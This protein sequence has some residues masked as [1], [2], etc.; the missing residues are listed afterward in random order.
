MTDGYFL[1]YT[2]QQLENNWQKSIKLY[3]MYMYMKIKSQTY[4]IVIIAINLLEFLVS[5][6][7]III[8][9]IN[10]WLSIVIRDY[11]FNWIKEGAR[12]TCFS[13]CRAEEICFRDIILFRYKVISEYFFLPISETE[14]CVPSNADRKL[15]S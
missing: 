3:Y 5:I 10:S 12:G 15:F 4:L 6:S 9:E 13:L 8:T 1:P 7:I 2:S 11:P 14:I